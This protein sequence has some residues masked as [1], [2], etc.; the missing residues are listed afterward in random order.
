MYRGKW[1]DRTDNTSFVKRTITLSVA[2]EQ[3][4]VDQGEMRLIHRMRDAI[5]VQMMVL[6]T[7][8]LNAWQTSRC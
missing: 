3:R 5:K 1:Q 4:A 6:F 7:T 8:I 2:S